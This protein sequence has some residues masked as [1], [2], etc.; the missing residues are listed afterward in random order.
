MKISN[1][2]GIEKFFQKFEDSNLICL[3]GRGDSGKTTILH[4]IS[5]VLSPTWNLSFCDTD[6]YN[7]DIQN[8]IEIE[9]TLRDLPNSLIR[10]DKFGLYI[11][12]YDSISKTVSPEL[13]D[14]QEETLT[15]R[16]VVESD[17]EPKWYVVTERNENKIEIHARDRAR[18]STFLIADQVDQH[19]S[20]R[21]G[22]PLNSIILN[23]SEIENIES[24]II[25]D[26]LRESKDKID[27]HIFEKFI[28]TIEEITT[29]SKALGLNFTNLKSAIDVREFLLKENRIILHDK[30]IPLRMNGK[31]SKRLASLAIQLCLADSKGIIL[32]DEIEGGLEPD[33]AQNL[34]AHLKNEKNKQV[35]MTTHSRD[36][37]V[38]L[39]ASNLYLMYNSNSNLI[40]FSSSMQG[41]LRRNPEAFYARKVI[42]CEGP[43]EIGVCKALDDFRKETGLSS[44]VSK[45]IRLAD[46]T[47]DEMINYALGFKQTGFDVLLFCDSDKKEVNEKKEELKSL[48]I[49][50]VDWPDQDSL[51]DAIF[52]N[53]KDEDIYNLITLVI[54]FKSK[55]S[56]AN[57]KKELEEQFFQ[58]MVNKGH[59]DFEAQFVSKSFSESA[60]IDLARSAK[61]KRWFKTESKGRKLGNYLFGNLSN[62]DDTNV[63][64]KNFNSLSSWI[65]NA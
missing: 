40:Q 8:A 6:F 62:F 41:I 10:D 2:R 59:R 31:G 56:S 63:L 33:R 42:I 61:S 43:T 64:R 14:G 3:I 4:A 20:W 9:V 22:S 17:L 36:V 13:Q 65:N 15:V 29:N 16:L 27:E 37:L 52:K 54:D 26:V 58:A 30:K 7:C 55:E 38:E 49:N 47:G 19:F 18:F 60:K 24:K 11:Q 39:D 48:G 51:E 50:I 28:K 53:I 32:I 21:K 5:F 25:L 34:S 23:S 45:G 57:S 1:F 12:G 35:F 44:L 46:G